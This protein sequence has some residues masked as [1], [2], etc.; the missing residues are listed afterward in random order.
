M[1]ERMETE[2]ADT[3][4]SIFPHTVSHISGFSEP[5][6][7]NVHN[8]QIN[9]KP[10]EH[11]MQIQNEQRQERLNLLQKYNGIPVPEDHAQESFIQEHGEEHCV[12]LKN[13]YTIYK[14][15]ISA[16]TSKRGKF[17]KWYLLC[18]PN[19]VLKED[20][21]L[22]RGILRKD[23]IQSL[24]QLNKYFGLTSQ[25]NRLNVNPEMCFRVKKIR[26]KLRHWN[27][28]FGDLKEAVSAVEAGQFSVLHKCE[29]VN[30]ITNIYIT[31]AQIAVDVFYK[32]PAAHYMLP[33]VVSLQQK[34]E[35]CK[36]IQ[37]SY[38]EKRRSLI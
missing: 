13:G 8:F 24:E 7:G 21:K 19:A 5:D 20:L 28:M 2:Y 3:N 38:A 4:S 23:R 17:A 10:N 26:N 31:R 12:V 33:L 16:N 37:Q 25:R 30:Q 18:D 22:Q 36:R 32:E 9:Q 11:E 34:V 35:A 15:K 27:A 6:L 14:P 29:Q 1:D